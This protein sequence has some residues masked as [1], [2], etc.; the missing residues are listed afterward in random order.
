MI[1]MF[2]Q[3]SFLLYDMDA[4]QPV[5]DAAARI[6]TQMNGRGRRFVDLPQN[7]PCR[8]HLPASSQPV[9]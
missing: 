6:G 3:Q 2:E 7:H 8:T 9:P 1:L 5:L 4:A